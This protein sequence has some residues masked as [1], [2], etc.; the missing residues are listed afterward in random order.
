VY[1]SSGPG[2]SS[3]NTIHRT[4]IQDASSEPDPEA[5]KELIHRRLR[6]LKSRPAMKL[7]VRG[8]VSVI[9]YT[10]DLSIHICTLL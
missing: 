9:I 6:R 1:R 10:L 4:H 8:I 2:G 7:D 3:T 5:E